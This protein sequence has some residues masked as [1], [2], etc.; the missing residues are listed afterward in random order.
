MPGR[1]RTRGRWVV[2]C[3]LATALA[4][5]ACS[6]PSDDPPP[7]TRETPLVPVDTG[8][9]AV[10]SGADTFRV[11]VELAET[12]E[13]QRTGLMERDSMPEDEGMLFLYDEPRQPDDPFYM[14]R[15]R[16]PLDIAFFDASGTI[17]AIRQMEPCQSRYP[18]DCPLYTPGQPYLGALEVNRGW[19][20]SRGVGVG[21][22]IELS[23]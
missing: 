18:A 3:L 16:I 23:R 6:P 19:L 11:R 1:V 22:R 4:S 7:V 15:T 2:S 13:Q 8:T 14:F 12:P 5:L 17:V 20:E 9:A 21:D 10:I